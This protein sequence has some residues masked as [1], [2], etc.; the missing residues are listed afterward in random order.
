MSCSQTIL[1]IVRQELQNMETSLTQQRQ[2]YFTSH[3]EETAVSDTFTPNLEQFEERLFSLETALDKP[4]CTYAQNAELLSFKEELLL[5]F[6]QQVPQYALSLSAEP[7]FKVFQLIMCD[8]KREHNQV[9]YAD[10]AY[11]MDYANPQQEAQKKKLKEAI[12]FILRVKQLCKCDFDTALVLR[13]LIPL[14]PRIGDIGAQPQHIQQDAE[15]YMKLPMLSA[16]SDD[17][18]S[19][20]LQFNIW[21]NFTAHI[22][23]Q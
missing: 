16:I 10:Y 1:H 13:H 14:L 19:D 3:L 23:L 11:G 20:A 15:S 2:M 17:Y 8:L 7:V 9:E 6:W 18:M 12:L 5:R 4:I 21:Y 22:R